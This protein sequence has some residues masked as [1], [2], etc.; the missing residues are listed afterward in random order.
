MLIDQVF[1]FKGDKECPPISKVEIIDFIKDKMAGVIGCM[2]L[3]SVKSNIYGTFITTGIEN[4]LIDEEIEG[5]FECNSDTTTHKLFLSDLFGLN[6]KNLEEASCGFDPRRN[7]FNFIEE[8]ANS[9]L[10]LKLDLFIDLSDLEQYRWSAKLHLTQKN[11]VYSQL[12]SFISNNI[13]EK[14]KKESLL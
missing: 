14:L 9:Y 11:K 2:D 3:Y 8:K 7:Y 10:K 4:C 1:E 13:F 6:I 5:G 12:F